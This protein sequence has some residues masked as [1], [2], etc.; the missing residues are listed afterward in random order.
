MSDRTTDRAA[1][2]ACLDG[3]AP[4]SVWAA[5][6]AAPDRCCPVAPPSTE[7]THVFRANANGGCVTCGAPI[8]AAVH[9]VT[10]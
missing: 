1:I 2:L 3:C 10:A 6:M 4:Q 8:S 7:P 5:A 9:R